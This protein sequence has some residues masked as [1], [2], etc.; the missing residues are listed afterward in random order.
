MLIG[1]K[2]KKSKKKSESRNSQRVWQTGGV[3]THPEN[4]GKVMLCK[5][6]NKETCRFDE[7]RLNTG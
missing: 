6:Y 5:L 3:Q 2:L 1:C 7:N 4:A